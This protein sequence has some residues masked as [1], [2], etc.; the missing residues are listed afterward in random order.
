MGN[1]RDG[2]PFDRDIGV[3]VRSM[4]S[5]TI[6]TSCQTFMGPEGCVAHIVVAPSF[7]LDLQRP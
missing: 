3:R 6:L 2:V 7:S 5:L 1:D 4:F